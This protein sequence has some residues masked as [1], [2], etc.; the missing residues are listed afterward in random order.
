M[1][2]EGFERHV[3]V[4]NQRIKITLFQLLRRRVFL[5]AWQSGSKDKSLANRPKWA[6]QLAIASSPAAMAAMDGLLNPAADAVLPVEIKDRYMASRVAID[7]PDD[8]ILSRRA[9]RELE[10]RFFFHITT[11]DDLQALLRF[12]IEASQGAEAFSDDD[13]SALAQEVWQLYSRDSDGHGWAQN[14]EEDHGDALDSGGNHIRSVVRN[15]LRP[16]GDRLTN[17]SEQLAS[18]QAQLTSTE[19]QLAKLISMVEKMGPPSD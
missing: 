12:G 7:A 10:R 19:Q 15:E 9:A 13:V 18:V 5:L 1:I 16:V 4:A 17:H 8:E 11:A 14:V 3:D 6:R 2:V